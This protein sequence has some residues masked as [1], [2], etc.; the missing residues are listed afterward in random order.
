MNAQNELEKAISAIECRMDDFHPTIQG[1]LETLLVA[2][3]QV[4]RLNKSVCLL[5]DYDAIK[6]ELKVNAYVLKDIVDGAVHP[7]SAIRRVMV[8]LEPIR[9]A[10]EQP[11]TKSILTIK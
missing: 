8:D 1:F 2:A 7:E 6:S 9:K 11:I 5:A 10:V 3:K 4:D